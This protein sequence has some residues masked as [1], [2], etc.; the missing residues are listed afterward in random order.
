MDRLKGVGMLA[1]AAAACPCH[2]PILLALLGGTTIGVVLAANLLLVVVLLGAVF[3]VALIVGLRA[4]ETGT[5]LRVAPKT[6]GEF[7]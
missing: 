6:R 4:L 7:R 5:R 1:L 2:L 3:A